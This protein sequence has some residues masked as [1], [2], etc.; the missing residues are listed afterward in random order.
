MASGQ[1]EKTFGG[2]NQFIAKEL[3]TAVGVFLRSCVIANLVLRSREQSFKLKRLWRI[4]R[5]IER[6]YA[7]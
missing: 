2:I 6:T 4:F 5:C 3:D 1:S 7:E